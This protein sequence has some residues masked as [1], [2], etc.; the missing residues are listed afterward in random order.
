MVFHLLQRFI[1]TPVHRPRDW[2]F[3]WYDPRPGWDK[4]AFSRAIFALD[5]KYKLFSDGRL[6]AIDGVDYKEELLDPAQFTAEA[7]SCQ[8]EARKSHRQNDATSRLQRS[9]NRGRRLRKSYLKKMKFILSLFVICLPLV[10]GEKPNL[11]LNHC[12]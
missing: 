9:T 12:G 1:S 11:V 2:V 8:S 7:K 6:F 3:F 10:A 4:M 5:H